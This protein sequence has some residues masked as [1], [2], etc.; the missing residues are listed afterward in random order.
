M[1]SNANN[2]FSDNASHCLATTTA[3][4]GITSMTQIFTKIFGSLL[5]PKLIP[6]GSA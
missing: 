1:A 2:F 4:Q 5:A 6:N 3:N